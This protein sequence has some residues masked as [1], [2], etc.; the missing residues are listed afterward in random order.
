MRSIAGVVVFCHH[1]HVQATY[2]RGV[3]E[4][5]SSNRYNETY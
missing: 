5:S 4:L 1:G 3:I 2:M